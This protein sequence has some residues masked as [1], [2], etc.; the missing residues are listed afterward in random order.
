[1]ISCLSLQFLEAAAQVAAGLGAVVHQLLLFDEIDHGFG[2]GG[3]HGVAAEGGDGDA[4]ESVGD[5]RLGDGQPD[6]AAVAEALGAGHDVGRDAPLLDAEPLAAGASP[7]GLHFVADEDAAVIAD[8][9]LDD[10]EVFLGRRD[11]AADALDRLG[12]EAGDAAA[13]GGADQLF[14]VLRAA[15]FAIGIGQA[16]RA[17]IAVRVVRVDDAGL[18]RARAARCPGR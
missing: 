18:R 5:F 11:E 7:A 17:A 3:G 10:L 14:H 13:G 6:G 8:D 2:G 9:L 16:E 12:D 1:M 4:L 15:H